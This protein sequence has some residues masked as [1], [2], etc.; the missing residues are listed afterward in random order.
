MKQRSLAGIRMTKVGLWFVLLTLL[1]SVA[2]T[3]TGNNALYMV[4]TELLATLVVS[5]IASRNNLRRLGLE[6]KPPA[7]IFANAPFPVRYRLDNGGRLLPR[8]Y[9][10]LTLGPEDQAQTLVVPKLGPR[11]HVDG[12]VDLLLPR[13]GRHRF[14]EAVVWSLFPFGLFRRGTRRPG[15]EEVLVYPEV[16]SAATCHLEQPNQLGEQPLP[17]PGW[18]HD[19]HALRVFRS[20]DDPRGIH[21]KQTARTG[22]LIF[23]ERE[24]EESRRLSILLDNAVGPFTDAAAAARFERLIS[25][26][27]TAAVDYL[28]H[29]C[30]VELVT[31][32]KTVPFGGGR[33]QR[34]AILEVLALLETRPMERRPLE[35]PSGGAAE[36]RLALDERHA[37]T[38]GAPA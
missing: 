25:E 4:L 9:L 7:E 35:S 10:L 23:K 36:L 32:D 27:A 34:R 33:R 21:W 1:V 30:E 31:R 5:G 13:R 18:G 8:Y 2:A 14:T 3:N 16:F 17:R 22:D 38:S 29:G 24:A 6:V 20:G 28:E 37:A 26:A 19:L 12:Q 11:A 15:G